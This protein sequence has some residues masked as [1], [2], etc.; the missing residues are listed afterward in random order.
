[1]LVLVGKATQNIAVHEWMGFFCISTQECIR[2]SVGQ[3]LQKQVYSILKEFAGPLYSA[4]E[5]LKNPHEECG[6]KCKHP[7]ITR[8]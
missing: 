4:F 1:M 5:T 8:R 7:T 2:K 6:R 3:L